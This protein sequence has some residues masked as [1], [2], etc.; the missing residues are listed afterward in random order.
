MMPQ[1]ARFPVIWGSVDQ[2]IEVEVTFDWKFEQPQRKTQ[3]IT[4]LNTVKLVIKDRCRWTVG[5]MHN[6][7]LCISKDS[8]FPVKKS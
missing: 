2:Q 8:I 7:R 3:T 6:E 1:H 4:W 5:A